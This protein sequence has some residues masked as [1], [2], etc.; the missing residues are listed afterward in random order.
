MIQNIIS[1]LLSNSH[2]SYYFSDLFYFF[3]DFDKV[4]IDQILYILGSI[5]YVHSE[6][7]GGLTDGDYF[8]IFYGNLALCLNRWGNW[9]E[10]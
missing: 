4:Y 1:Y 7:I 6:K 3:V 5:F 8:F 2:I 10:R 9:V